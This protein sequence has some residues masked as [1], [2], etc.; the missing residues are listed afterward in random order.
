MFLGIDPGRWKIGFAAADR[1]R[2]LF[3]AII[4]KDKEGAL[5]CA[6]SSRDISAL[7]RWAKEGRAEDAVFDSDTKIFIGDGTSSGELCGKLDPAA[8]VAV[9]NEYGTTLAGRKLYWKLHP[10]V[11]L[12]RL[13]PTSL[14][15]PPRD[16]DD[17][18]AWAIIISALDG[19]TRIN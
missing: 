11:G 17:L 3:S 1:D 14:R 15:V 2:L 10:P 8:D 16:I 18:A 19:P 12:W 5:I 13:I 4:P 7:D 9:V 6:V